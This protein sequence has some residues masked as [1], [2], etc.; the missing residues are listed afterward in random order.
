MLRVVGLVKLSGRVDR[1]LNAKKVSLFNF[2]LGSELVQ[3][4]SSKFIEE[5]RFLVAG[6]NVGS[7]HSSI[8]LSTLV[9]RKRNSGNVYS[10]NESSDDVASYYVRV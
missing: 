8:L 6:V 10:D 2:F 5:H 4:S 9:L 7:P 3:A 1:I